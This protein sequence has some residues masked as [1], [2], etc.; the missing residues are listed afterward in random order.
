MIIPESDVNYPDEQQAALGLL[1]ESVKI[2]QQSGIDFVIIGG[3][4]P[5]LFTPGQYKH[6]GT[7]D[8]DVVFHGKLK[9]E[10]V[11]MAGG[12][13]EQ[14]GYLPAA[15][16][17]FQHYRLLKT[18]SRPIAYHIDFLHRLYAQDQEDFMLVHWNTDFQS[19]AGPGTDV[20][21]LFNERTTESFQTT[22]PNGTTTTVKADFGSEVAVLATKGRSMS[23]PKR[24]RDAF[25]IF[26]VVYQSRDRSELVRKSRGLMG[27]KLYA[28][29][30]MKIRQQFTTG[31][32]VENV[33]KFIETDPVRRVPDFNPE[34]AHF[35][36][37]TVHDFLDEVEVPSGEYVRTDEQIAKR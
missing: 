10:Q 16:N 20:I 26:L 35:I 9:R 29:S 34:L 25:D 3:W 28:V 32:A 31:K 19:F 11:E 14:A 22:L 27:A 21:F 4:I 6:P 13:L 30:L 37:K 1:G 15:K 17:K 5:F 18:N 7:V 23:S 12:L 24:F 33:M 8:V 36:S 2:L